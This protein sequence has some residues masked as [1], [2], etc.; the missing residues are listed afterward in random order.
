MDADHLDI[1]QDKKRLEESYNLFANQVKHDG[2]LIYKDGIPLTCNHPNKFSYSLNAGSQYAGVD[3]R[4]EN[5]QYVFNLKAPDTTYSNIKL[6]LPGRHNAENAVAAC[7]I[8]LNLGLTIEQIKEALVTY[9]GVKR[10]FDLQ[11][12]NNQCVFIDDYAHH[13]EELNACIRSVKEMYT[14]KKITGI[15]QP[16]LFSRTRDF[17]DGFAQSLS[18]LDE[19]ILLE[20]YPARELPIEGINSSMLLS[21]IKNNSK[22]LLNKEQVLEYIKST[23]SQVLLTLGAGDID[24]LVEPI[25]KI[26][27]EKFTG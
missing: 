1:Y 26:L 23:N 21:K 7:A 4:V 15:F 12:K 5:Y 3:L 10:R 6:G 24:T 17:A 8:A 25:R 19:V 16:H 18:L 9:T 14:G 27:T 20:I 11:F 13:P 22:K 2:V